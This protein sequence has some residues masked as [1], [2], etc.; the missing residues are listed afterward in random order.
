MSDTYPKKFVGLHS[1]DHFSTFDAIGTPKEHIDF[2]IENGM[3]ALAN[4]NHGNANS[5][6]Q[7]YNYNQELKKKGIPFKAIYGIEVLFRIVFVLVLLL[8]IISAI[9]FSIKNNKRDWNTLEELKKKAN[10]VSTKEEI[11][12]FHKEFVEKAN[13]IYNSEIKPELMK[14]DGYLR[15]LYKQYKNIK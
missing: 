6:A 9:S 5:F 2:A 14:I 15:G 10:Q 8:L 7:L 1:H 11:E 12:E 4:T 13:K 3:D